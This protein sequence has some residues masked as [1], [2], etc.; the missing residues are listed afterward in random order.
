VTRDIGTQWEDAACGHLQRS[1]LQLLARIF[2]CRYGEIDL[3]M[4]DADPAAQHCVVFV[5]VRYRHTPVRGDGID[6]VGPA[7]RPKLMRAAAVYLQAHPR[8]GA[9]PCRFDVV[10]RQGTPA[11]P[12]MEWIRA[13][14]AHN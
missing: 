6:S 3:V 11:R 2:N 13:A 10:A 8:L 1:G 14:F 9:Q 7:K 4:L 12:Q 5:E